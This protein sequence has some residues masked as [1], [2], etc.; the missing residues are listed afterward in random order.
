MTEVKRFKDIF[1]KLSIYRGSSDLIW[2]AIA[3]VVEHGVPTR[4][5]VRMHHRA[6][7]VSSL[8]QMRL[9]SNVD[10]F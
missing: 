1:D 5:L 9:A 2:L 3:R 4:D 7:S 6:P 10:D 8:K